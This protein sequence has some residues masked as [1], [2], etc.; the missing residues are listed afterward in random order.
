MDSWSERSQ[1]NNEVE[2]MNYN[3]AVST[4][5]GMLRLEATRRRH[6]HG[7]VV[8]RP[9]GFDLT[10]SQMEKLSDWLECGRATLRL[11]LEEGP[12]KP[13]VVVPGSPVPFKFSEEE[14]PSPARDPYLEGIMAHQPLPVRRKIFR[15]P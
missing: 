10:P 7:Q 3:I 9:G 13:R 5:V 12:E 6:E 15:K 8:E 2:V 4:L 1:P 14:S 11:P